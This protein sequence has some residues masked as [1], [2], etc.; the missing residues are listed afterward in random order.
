MKGNNKKI[1]VILGPNAAGKSALAIKLAKKFGGE[2][3]S[4]DS[5]QVYKGMDIGT[6]KVTK[7]E[8]QGIPHYLLDVASP[9]R[10]FTVAQYVK[11]AK[12]AIEK[13][14][15][16][17]KIPIICG[18]T[19]FYITALVDGLKIPEVKPDWKLRKKL[20]K[21]SAK[22]LFE[23]L[24]KLD[25]ERAKTIEKENKRRLIRAIEI[26]KKL[27]KVPKL[28]KE[29][30]PYPVLFLGIKRDWNELKRKIKRRLSKRLKKGMIAEV[31]KLRESGVS[32]KRL[33]EFGLEYRWI[34][35][36]LQGK[37]SKKEMIEK[38]EKEIFQFAK[39]QMR[40]FK[41]YM[42]QTIWIKNQK[43]AEKLVRNFL[44]K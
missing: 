25:K 43:E 18:G 32:F 39:R 15:K 40:Y 3:I 29:P 21:K 42:P 38:L 44:E 35:Y 24:K 19:G 7:K 9:K 33:K 4:A 37:V 5:R 41:K 30:L 28:K 13:I 23:M 2:I 31:K 20:E 22:E 6:G 17:G 27:K 12:K 11:L 1:I 34:S 14:F 36:Y 10:K 16:K 26:A 8:M